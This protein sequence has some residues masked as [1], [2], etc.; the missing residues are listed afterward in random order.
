MTTTKRLLTTLLVVLLI[1]QYARA[2]DEPTAALAQYGA[3]TAYD[4][5]LEEMGA[6]EERAAANGV[7]EPFTIAI[8]QT[9]ANALELAAYHLSWGNI[10]FQQG[11]W[12]MA[13][14][15]YGHAINNASAAATFFSYVYP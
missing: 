6:A 1:S 13:W 9:G 14:L 12:G 2:T 11:N 5:A 7:T 10:Y 4:I 15:H 3:I 8:Y